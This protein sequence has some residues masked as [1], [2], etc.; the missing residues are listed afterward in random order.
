[1]LS[2]IRQ[3]Y[4]RDYSLSL[5]SEGFWIQLDKTTPHT[6]LSHELRRQQVKRLPSQCVP[7]GNAWL[8]LSQKDIVAW[9][10]EDQVPKEKTNV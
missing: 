1:M 8:G 3:P 5:C 7:A 9:P 2:S 6:T 10:M 4:T